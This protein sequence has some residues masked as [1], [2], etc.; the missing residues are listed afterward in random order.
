[1]LVE[2]YKGQAGSF[3]LYEDEG[4]GYNYEKGEFAT[5]HIRWEDETGQLVITER[6]VSYSNMKNDKVS[7]FIYR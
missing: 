5:I 6:K 4:D 1:M 2:H 3:L 7:S